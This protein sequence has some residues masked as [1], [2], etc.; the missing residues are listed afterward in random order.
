MQKG[1]IKSAIKI[2]LAEDN[3]GDVLL[4]REALASHGFE[5]ELVVHEDGEGMM[6]FIELLDFDHVEL[7]PD[8]VLLDLNLPRVDGEQI[9]RRIRASGKFAQIP[10]IIVTSS[11]SPQDRE[12]TAR[13]AKTYYFRKP[14]DFDEFLALGRVVKSAIGR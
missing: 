7:L 13:F 2:V 14:A 5:F 6:K 3:P 1:A 8:V 9:L 11:D 4:V 10:V 12:M